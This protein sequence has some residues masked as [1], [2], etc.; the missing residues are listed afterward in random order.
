MISLYWNDII[1]EANKGYFD[2]EDV[3]EMLK[4]FRAQSGKR[5][6]ASALKKRK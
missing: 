3:K 2:Y 4:V 6:D 1:R 5:I